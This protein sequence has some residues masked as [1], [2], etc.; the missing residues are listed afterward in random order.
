MDIKAVFF[1]IGSILIY[2]P[3]SEEPARL[4]KGVIALLKKLKSQNLKLGII[5][6][7]SFPGRFHEEVLEKLKILS[8]FDVKVWSSEVGFKKPHPMIFYQAFQN[9]GGIAPGESVYVGDQFERDI[10]SANRAGLWAIWITRHQE[11]REITFGWKIKGI[12][13]AW[14]VIEKNLYKIDISSLS[15]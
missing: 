2:D 15:R 14:E 4:R 9:L 6:N 8:Y 3:S 11:K 13:D 5:S 10:K 12:D 7:T 1:D